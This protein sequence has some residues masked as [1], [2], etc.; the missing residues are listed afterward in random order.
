ML[1]VPIG[2]DDVVGLGEVPLENG[3]ADASVGTGDEH[4]CEPWLCVVMY[5]DLRSYSAGCYLADCR[6]ARC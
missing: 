4:D 2:R 3:S 1:R 5:G 6:S